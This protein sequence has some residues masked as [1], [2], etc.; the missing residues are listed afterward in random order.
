MRETYEVNFD[1]LV[2]PTHNYAGLSFGNVASLA[3]R[4]LPSHPKAAALQGLEKMRLL[5]SLGI[6]QAIIPPHERPHMETLKKLGFGSVVEVPE[7]ILQLCSSS[8]SMWAAN[9]ATV[10]P[11]SDTKDQTVHITPA[12]MRSKPHRS[13]EGAFTKRF[14]QTIL[15]SEH[16]TIHD[17][18]PLFSDEGAANHI[19]FSTPERDLGLHL[20]VYGN[21]AKI[22]KFPAR[23]SKEAAEAL[24]R[25]HQLSPTQVVFAEQNP[26]AIDAGVFHNDVIATG[27]GLL[28]FY[29]EKSFAES[30]RVIDE[31]QQ[32]A[33]ALFGKS[34][35]LVEVKEEEI[36][37]EEAVKNYLFNSQIVRDPT[38]KRH[39]I[40]LK[41]CSIPS[42][43][44]VDMVHFVDLY[45]SM[46][47]GG[48]PA[49]LRLKMDLN[50]NELNG[51]KG[52]IFFGVKLYKE[53]KSWIEKH[54]RDT[55]TSKDLADPALSEEV[56]VALNELTQIMECGSLYDF[57]R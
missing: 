30:K 25:V 18:L 17:P 35:T 56:Q 32:K 19:R 4:E 21:P 23:Q 1:G 41:G 15:P 43:L 38:G 47:N 36:S 51:I 34:L 14:F 45:E 27:D 54:Y 11:S 8:A 40:A 49:C 29:H 22:K 7:E 42:K 31:L 5:H 53:I 55:L 57:Q 13:M 24:A 37:I 46:K 52:R 10:T 28:F 39:L 20:F 3:S 26:A 48:G 50:A 2:G 44:P 6:Q 16:F 33:E 9:A 12:N